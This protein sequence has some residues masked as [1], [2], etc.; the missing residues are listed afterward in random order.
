MR[1]GPPATSPKRSPPT[2]AWTAPWGPGRSW[3]TAPTPAACSVPCCTGP[4]SSRRS[5][6]SPPP[7]ASTCANAARTPTR[8]TTGR[9]WRAWA[10]PWPST[11]TA[12]CTS[13][14]PSAAGRSTTSAGTGGCGWCGSPR[15]SWR[16]RPPARSPCCSPAGG[17]RA[18]RRSARPSEGLLARV[19]ERQPALAEDSG[20]LVL[21]EAA[22][23]KGAPKTA[24]RLDRGGP[25]VT[26]RRRLALAQEAP[27]EVVVLL[28]VRAGDDDPPEAARL[29]GLPEFGQ[30]GEILEERCTLLVVDRLGLVV[31]FEPERVEGVGVGHRHL[32]QCGRVG[33]TSLDAVMVQ[34]LR[35]RVSGGSPGRQEGRLVPSGPGMPNAC[36]QAAEQ[37]W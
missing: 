32:V 16:A 25:A 29:Q 20:H 1:T 33:D 8:S 24:G 15:A 9:C 36:L 21:G 10:I 11:P 35:S 26:E 27:A 3:S 5:R 31:F 34:R 19:P 23:G 37:R 22:G 13:S 2:S 18:A 14:P 6:S 4:P 12:S 28:A 7:K 17:A 30:V